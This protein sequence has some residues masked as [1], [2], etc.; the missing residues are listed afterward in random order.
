MNAALPDSLM[1]FCEAPQRF[2][3]G[4][5]QAG[6]PIVHFR[7][8]DER[9][10]VLCDPDAS[11]GVLNGDADD[12]EKGDLYDIPRTTMGD[13]PI[14]SEHAQWGMQHGMLAPL[15]ARRRLRELEPLIG[16]TVVQLLDRWD[17]HDKASLELLPDCKRLAFDVVCRGLVGLD[18]TALTDELFGAVTTIDS[19]ESVR[20]YYLA[21]RFRQ[22]GAG[23]GFSRSG[24]G[25]A[26]ERMDELLAV[27]VERCLVRRESG[28]DMVGAAIASDMVRAMDDARRRR[29]LRDLVATLLMAGYSTTGESLFWAL[30][31]LARHPDV[32]R[33]AHEALLAREDGMAAPR[34]DVPPYLGAVFNESQRMYPPVW[35]MGRVA[36]RPVQLC[37]ETLMPG[38]RVLCSP[39]VLHHVP[40]LWPDPRRFM[41]ERFLAGAAAPIVARA[42]IPFGT[43]M[44]A[45]IGRG[46]A[47]MEMAALVGS[48]LRRFEFGLASHNEPLL[49]AAFATQPRD[50]VLFTLQAR[51]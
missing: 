23:D 40:Q 31:M 16:S 8:H 49:T 29:F 26:V 42:F 38:T 47:M 44:R 4:I 18:D 39:L 27:I 5:A 20:L 12:Y 43:G 11:H 24:L 34:F 7:L 10:V 51:A 13:G 46:L 32:Q 35:F 1:P 17:A 50:P 14:T 30:Y 36:R 25:R 28:D 41:P 45:C 37:G 2:L 15:F 48:A 21:K 22:A 19:T 33:R 6:A 3:L 9:F